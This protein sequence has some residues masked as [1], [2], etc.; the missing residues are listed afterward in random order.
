V[1]TT[2]V[3]AEAMSAVPELRKRVQWFFENQ[4]DKANLLMGCVDM[5]KTHRLMTMLTF[6]QRPRV[7]ERMLDEGEFLSD[8]G[9][10]ALSRA[11]KNQPFRLN[12][13]GTDYSVDYEPGESHTTMFGGNSNWRGPVWFPVNYLLIDALDRHQ[14]FFGDGNT[15]P[16]PTGSGT[17]KTYGQVADDLAQRL[18]GV[19]LNDGA[20]RRPVFGDVKLFQEDPDWHDHIPFHEYFHGDTGAGIGA[21]HQTGW[22]ALAINLLLRKGRAREQAGAAAAAPVAEE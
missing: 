20:G 8:H 7:L 14:D 16:Y 17:Q 5:N 18:V 11:H 19:F 3:R 13:N 15:M 12:I 6:D 9:L 4:S 10:R 22:T 1:A 2:S 21:S